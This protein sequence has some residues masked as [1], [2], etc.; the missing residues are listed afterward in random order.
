MN[1]LISK[2]NWLGTALVVGL[3]LS[4][5]GAY[6][7]PDTFGDNSTRLLVACLGAALC[8]LS[9]RRFFLSDAT[10]PATSTARAKQQPAPHFPPLSMPLPGL[11]FRRPTPIMSPST[12]EPDAALPKR[13][14]FGS[15]SHLVIE[16]RTEDD[17]DTTL[18]VTAYGFSGSQFKSKIRP[19]LE[20][21]SGKGIT[22]SNPVN[23]GEQQRKME[24]TIAAGADVKAVIARIARN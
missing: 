7:A 22:W 5:I 24:C 17:G 6:S 23:L 19:R 2:I 4:F 1:S 3:A 9:T 14:D 10:A 11:A 15:G 20:N 8:L 18:T 12:Q 13:V 16:A 21:I